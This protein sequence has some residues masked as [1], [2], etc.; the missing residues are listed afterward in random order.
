MSDGAND[1]D[2]HTAIHVYVPRPF[3]NGRSLEMKLITKIVKKF[4]VLALLSAII[5]A[6]LI[7]AP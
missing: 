7:T 5:G 1:I 2:I 6:T 3:S 4:V